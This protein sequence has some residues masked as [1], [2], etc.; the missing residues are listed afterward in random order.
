MQYS[1][2]HAPITVTGSSGLAVVSKSNLHLSSNTSCY[3][4]NHKVRAETK[5]REN[6]VFESSEA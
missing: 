4:Q 1:A 5:L 3:Y 2:N 6:D